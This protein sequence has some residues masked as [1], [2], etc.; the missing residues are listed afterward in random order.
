MSSAGANITVMTAPMVD[1]ESRAGS[2]AG[3]DV[4]VVA[5]DAPRR[6]RIAFGLAAET[7][8]DHSPG[9]GGSQPEVVEGKHSVSRG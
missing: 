1:A 7:Q 8:L 4:T 9:E 6:Q 2:D 5:E 3:S